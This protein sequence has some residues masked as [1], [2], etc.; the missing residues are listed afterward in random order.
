MGN[1]S[2]WLWLALLFILGC[3]YLSIVWSIGFISDDWDLIHKAGNQSLW[4]PLEGHHYSLFANLIFKGAA[5]G[6][7][8]PVVIHDCIAISLCKY[9][10]SVSHFV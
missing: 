2:R 4:E 3:T 6:W 7:I 10:I 8:S 5:L 9:L 1:L